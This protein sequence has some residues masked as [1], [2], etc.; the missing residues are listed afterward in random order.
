MPLTFGRIMAV[1]MIALLVI[2]LVSCSGFFVAFTF[3]F[4]QQDRATAADVG[5]VLF[6]LLMGYTPAVCIL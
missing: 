5:Y 2:I 3:S 6:Q 4:G 1:D